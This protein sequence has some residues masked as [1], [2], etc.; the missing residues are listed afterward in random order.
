MTQDSLRTLDECLEAAKD[1]K[2]CIHIL[3]ALS[4]HRLWSI[5]VLVAQNP[6][7]PKNALE[8]LSQEPGEELGNRVVRI[9]AAYTLC[10][11]LDQQ[12]V[13]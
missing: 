10:L 12:S 7:T 5:R 13:G 11:A 9:A 2:S 3:Q 4:Q 6:N 1:P 8:A